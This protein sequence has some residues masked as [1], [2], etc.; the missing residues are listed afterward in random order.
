M[1]ATSKRSRAPRR[2]TRRRGLRGKLARVQ[3]TDRTWLVQPQDNAFAR[4]HMVMYAVLVHV[5]RHEVMADDELAHPRVYQN[6]ALNR[7]FVYTELA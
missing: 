3:S 6:T 4:I 7:R 1:R 2:D 5:P